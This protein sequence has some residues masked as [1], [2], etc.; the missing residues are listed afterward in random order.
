MRCI[1][2]RYINFLFY[3]ILLGLKNRVGHFP[4]VAYFRVASIWLAIAEN[5]ERAPLAAY[6]IY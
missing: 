1:I 2:L 4:S 3:S 5:A 6:R